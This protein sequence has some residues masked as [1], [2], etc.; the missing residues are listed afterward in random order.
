MLAPPVHSH[1]LT[2]S[3]DAVTLTDVAGAVSDIKRA[4]A[5]QIA[6]IQ[7]IM[8]QMRMLA[9]NAKIESARA[10]DAGRGFA[11]VADEVHSVGDV[12]G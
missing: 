10:G 7:R 1:P 11:V 4:S 6:Q 12:V 5:D 3:D 9:L 8:G 2:A